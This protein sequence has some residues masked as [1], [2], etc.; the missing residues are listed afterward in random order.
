MENNFRN[1]KEDPV[2]KGD[3]DF[4]TVNQSK[5]SFTVLIS[6]DIKSLT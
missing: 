6:R 4:I 3:L 1:G 5:V 2:L